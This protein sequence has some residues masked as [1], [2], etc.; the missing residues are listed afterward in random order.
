MA[1]VAA[2]YVILRCCVPPESDVDLKPDVFMLKHAV[3]DRGGQLRLR[4]SG[5][6]L[7]R[8]F[9]PSGESA[10]AGLLLYDR[11]VCKVLGRP[12]CD[13]TIA[14][15]VQP[16]AVKFVDEAARAVSAAR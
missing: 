9:G 2:T 10:L 11:G 14:I 16:H 13:E 7:G 5:G 8:K 6:V 3:V 12:E 4:S 15:P 1:D